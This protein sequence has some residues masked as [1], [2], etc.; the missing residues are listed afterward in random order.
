MS[1][2]KQ[3]MRKMNSSKFQWLVANMVLLGFDFI[4]ELSKKMVNGSKRNLSENGKY[5]EGEQLFKK[6]SFP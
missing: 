6:L 4:K 5:D 2:L 3:Q 1:K